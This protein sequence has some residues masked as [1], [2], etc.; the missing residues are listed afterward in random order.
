MEPEN[1]SPALM[2]LREKPEVPRIDFSVY[3]QDDGTV[4][5]TKDRVIKGKKVNER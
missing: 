2:R 1:I 3:T 4:V 5:S